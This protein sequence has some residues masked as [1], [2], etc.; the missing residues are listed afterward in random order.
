MRGVS[1]QE[2]LDEKTIPA[3]AANQDGLLFFVNDSFQ[4]EYGWSAEDLIDNPI[5]TILPPNMREAHNLGFSRFLTTGTERIINK[6]I[7]LPVL[8][9]NGTTRDATH[10]IVAD[11]VEGEWVFAASIN[12]E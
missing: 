1:L 4:E 3:V 6:D 2:I 8:C 5:T 9:K 7:S 11:K 10:H 12:P